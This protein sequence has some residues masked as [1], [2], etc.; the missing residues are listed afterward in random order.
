M[1]SSGFLEISRR[2]IKRGVATRRATGPGMHVSVIK[3][4]SKTYLAPHFPTPEMDERKIL[5]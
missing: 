3:P 1:A 4:D 2:R 5:L